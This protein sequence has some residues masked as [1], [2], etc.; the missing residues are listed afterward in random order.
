MTEHVNAAHAV[1]LTKDEYGV[2]GRELMKERAILPVSSNKH[3]K[4][5]ILPT[6][7]QLR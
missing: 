1:Q 3:R 6:T 2:G 7:H 4:V 5:G